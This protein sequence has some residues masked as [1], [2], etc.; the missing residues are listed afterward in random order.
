MYVY[1]FNLYINVSFMSFVCF[2]V[3]LFLF[4]ILLSDSFHMIN[5]KFVDDVITKKH[6]RPQ[7]II[8]ATFSCVD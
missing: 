5:N 4:Y 7:N 6:F 3:L 8:F 2:K 1:C